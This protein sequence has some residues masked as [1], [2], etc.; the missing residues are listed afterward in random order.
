MFYKCKTFTILLLLSVPVHDLTAFLFY[1]TPKLQNGTGTGT[2]T[3]CTYKFIQVTV[4]VFTS[5]VANFI[6]N[7]K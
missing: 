5:F 7:I 3:Y 1:F 6:R 4:P 2:G